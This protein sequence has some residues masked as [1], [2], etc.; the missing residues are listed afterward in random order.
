MSKAV[1]RSLPYRVL[2]TL[3][4]DNAEVLLHPDDR[5]YGALLIG[6]MGSG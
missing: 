2:P 4:A 5:K 6:S 3:K 1:H